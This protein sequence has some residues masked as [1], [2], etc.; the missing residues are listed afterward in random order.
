LFYYICKIIHNQ[1][2]YF[3]TMKNIVTLLFCIVILPTSKSQNIDSLRTLLNS[4]KRDYAFYYQLIRAKDSIAPNNNGLIPQISSFFKPNLELNQ[5][6]SNLVQDYVPVRALDYLDS[7]SKKEQIIIFNEAHDNPY[8]RVAT[9]SY[10]ST[11]YK[12]GF[13]YLALESLNAKDKGINIR[14]YPLQDSSG[15]Y[16]NEPCYAEMVR[17]ALRLG[18][19][20]VPYEF[21]SRDI[22]LRERSQAENIYNRIF[23]KNPKAK[24]V[25]HCGYSHGL[26]TKIDKLPALMGY[27]LKEKSKINPFVVNQIDK[28]RGDITEPVFFIST[29]THRILHQSYE[30]DA[31]LFLPKPKLINNRP[32]WYSIGKKRQEYLPNLK[33]FNIEP[34]FLIQAFLKNESETAVPLDQ[35]EIDDINQPKGLWLYSGKY[36]FRVIDTN[37]VK[38]FEK[39][40]SIQID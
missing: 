16:V 4:G 17:E 39:E 34:P 21:E 30:G 22:D 32:N 9:T 3:T 6:E 35:I 20:L 2:K 13:R 31:C 19:T 28:I 33:E 12:N 38:K 37:N 27:Y 15:Y 40:I 29:K 23:A 11:L 18:F 7:I 26:D 25:I 14:K 10:L 36:I 1:N 5:N 24:V 8:H